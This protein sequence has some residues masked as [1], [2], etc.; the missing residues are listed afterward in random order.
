MLT[1][2]WEIA[3]WH[4]VSWILYLAWF[5]VKMMLFLALATRYL[6]KGKSLP[7]PCCIPDF[8]IFRNHLNSA[9]IGSSSLV[10]F[11]LSKGMNEYQKMD[12][13]ML[14]ECLDM[15]RRKILW[16]LWLY[17][18]NS[19]RTF[20]NINLIFCIIPQSTKHPQNYLIQHRTWSIILWGLAWGRE[21]SRGSSYKKFLLV[22]N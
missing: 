3:S 5:D 9:T 22:G 1:S 21:R 17:R 16:L 12:I 13:T 4:V 14:I 2:C 19:V 8:F 18:K 6:W 20:N 7:P 10:S 15:H 11:K